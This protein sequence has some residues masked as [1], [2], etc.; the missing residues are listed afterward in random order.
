MRETVARHSETDHIPQ[1][2]VDPH[3]GGGNAPKGL[4]FIDFYGERLWDL[5]VAEPGEHG[6][7]RG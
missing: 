3:Q 5:R 4:R 2:I 7:D 6:L 1:G